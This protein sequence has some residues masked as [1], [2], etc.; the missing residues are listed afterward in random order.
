VV[1]NTNQGQIV[2]VDHFI[3]PHFTKPATLPNCEVKFGT[4]DEISLK[5]HLMW[6]WNGEKKQL[7]EQPQ[8]NQTWD[9][10]FTTIE[11]PQQKQAVEEVDLVHAP[12]EHCDFNVR[13]ER[14]KS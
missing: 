4:N 9:I 1:N 8:E 11:P 5:D 14:R 3:E 7:T 12:R 6:K 2:L 13:W 10:G